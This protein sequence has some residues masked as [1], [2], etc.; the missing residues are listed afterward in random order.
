MKAI[1]LKTGGEVNP[2]DMFFV[3]INNPI[4]SM[5]MFGI[6]SNIVIF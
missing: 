4:I 6:D 3:T 5:I 1:P 2:F